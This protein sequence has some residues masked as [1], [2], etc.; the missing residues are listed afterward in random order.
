[1][2]PCQRRVTFVHDTRRIDRHQLPED[3]RV[4]WKGGGVFEYVFE[5]QII[6]PGKRNPV[7][8]GLHLLGYLLPPELF[9]GR[10]A[11]H[12]RHMFGVRQH[13]QDILDGAR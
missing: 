13:A 8:Q 11:D 4:R 1:M 12:H 10:S 2:K 6:V 3:G 7:F 5:R 9:N